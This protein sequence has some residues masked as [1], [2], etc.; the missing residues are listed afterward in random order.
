MHIV[1]PTVWLAVLCVVA[2]LSGPATTG[3]QKSAGDEQ[4]VDPFKEDGGGKPAPREAQ[5]SESDSSDDS[6]GGWLI[7][8]LGI[9]AIALGAGGFALFRRRDDGDA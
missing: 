1:R 4:Y 9:T 2:L 8:G 5:D 3:A 7:P 6:G